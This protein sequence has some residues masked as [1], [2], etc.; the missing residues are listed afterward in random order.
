MDQ[1]RE[2]IQEDLRGLIA[3]DVHCDDLFVQMYASDASIFEVQPIGVVRPRYTADVVACVQYAAANEIPL[4]PRGAGTGL[5][6]ESLGSGLIVDFSRYM[7]RIIDFDDDT[8]RLQPG[9]VHAS[10][11]A[12]LKPHGRVFGPD[13]AMSKV[14][15][16]GGTLGVD[17]SG[18]HWL[19]YGSASRHVVSMEL[20]LAD[21]EV[22]SAGREPVDGLV[23]QGGRKRMLVTELSAVFARHADVINAHR[24]PHAVDRCGYRV[25]GVLQDGFLDLPKLLCGSEG[26]LAMI[27]EATVATSPL[28]AHVGV[29]LLFFDQ[30]DKASQAVMEILP[31]GPSACDLMDR[32]HLS[33]AREADVRYDLLIPP[34]AEAMLLVEF[35]APQLEEVRERL[36][37][38]IDRLRD[39]KELAFDAHRTTDPETL[40]FYWQLAY[41]VVPTLYRL[42]GTS[43]PLPLVEDVS[44]P[45]AVLP[46]FLVRVQNVL[47]QHQVT[48]SLFGHVGHGQLHIRPFLDLSDRDD[49]AK[50]QRLAGDLYQEV[51]DVG[52]SI[53]GEHGS[54]LSRTPFLREHLG[55]LYDVFREIK[56]VFDPAGTLN[57]GKIVTDHPASIA[58]Y[59][60]TVHAPVS[61]ETETLQT[62]PLQL[63]WS[64]DEMTHAARECNGCGACRSQRPD[65][66]M[67]PIFR[68][69]PGEEASP[70]AKANLVRA[71]LTGRLDA[72]TVASDEFKEI[73]DLCVNCHQCRLECP[74][75]ADIPKL[76]VE[77]KAQY[78]S[79]NGLRPSEW[80]I[81]RIDLID[82]F[83]SWV[84]PLANWAITSPQARWLLEKTL[85]IAQGRKL[86]R[87]ARRSFLRRAARRKLTKPSE[88]DARKVL[89]FVD[90]Y[91]NH[92]DPQLAEAVVEVLQHNGIEVYVPTE[93]MYSAMPLIAV[94]AVDAARKIARHNTNLLADAVRQGYEIVASEPAATLCL[95]HEYRNLLDDD[96]AQLVAENTSDIGAYLWRM[97]QN[98]ELKLEL[99]SVEAKLGYHRPCHLKA[100][101]VGSPGE[102]LLGLIP[103]LEI[104]RTDKGCSG[105]AGT[106]GLM[107]KNYRSSLRAG[108]QVITSLR[109][110]LLQAGTT[111]CSACKMQMEQGTTK[112]TVHPIKLLALSYGLMPEIA[113]LLNAR[114]QEFVVT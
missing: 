17:S 49:V 66:R 84:Q 28:P 35:D 93:Q 8:V 15:T 67:C 103:G 32:R 34:Q 105:M 38:V 10:L 2:R 91:A 85:G 46:D 54:G 23:G 83:A 101:Q 79:T 7:R 107:R 87:L 19:R 3:G 6:G 42:K 94:G 90:V 80:L 43:R 20:V 51:D 77:A 24:S 36:A 14:T 47:K 72:E 29:A 61:S 22:I 113:D 78:L 108:R 69:S 88:T 50:M 5:A 18:S 12:M 9:V 53:G 56:Q 4:H 81:G 114:S 25:S 112:P 110:P 82:A 95:T 52:G 62:T 59:L 63:S 33:L 11:N 40:D 41:R 97:H 96:D 45:P 71:V 99:Q 65:V 1:E 75:E 48:A 27:T 30:S 76:M 92:H 111:E 89:Y 39:A 74:A 58:P 70:R 73:A 100:L 21:G 102:N 37:N 26:T 16:M 109:D 60:R 86:P 57:P 64:T 55:P 68:F 106:Y 44:I 31:Y 98:G 104:H 13:P